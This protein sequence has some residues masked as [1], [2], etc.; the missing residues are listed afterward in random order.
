MRAWPGTPY[1]VCGLVLLVV[2]VLGVQFVHK[3][4]VVEE[5]S[6]RGETTRTALGRWLPTARAFVQ[7]EDIYRIGH[8]FPNP[9]LVALAIAPLAYLPVWLAAVLWYL[10]K[11][12]ALL[13]SIWFA[14]RIL[15]GDD[16]KVPAA[17]VVMGL[18]FTSRSLVG[19]IQHGNINIF[20]GC[21]VLA[22]LWLLRNRRDAAAGLI[23]GLA[24][25][26][27]VLPGLFLVY[28]V[29]KRLWRAAL[30]MIGGGVVFGFV[31]PGLVVGLEQ[32]LGLLVGWFELMVLPIVQ[33]GAITVVPENQALFA[34]LLRVLAAA[35][36]LQLELADAA[37]GIPEQWALGAGLYVPRA[38]WAPW[39]GRG[40]FVAVVA[41][42]LWFS[43]RPT[44]DRS[45][46]R[47][48]VEYSLVLVAMLL[49]SERTWKHHAVTL[50]LPA[51][52]AWLL[53]A[54]YTPDKRRRAWLVAA[55]FVQLALAVGLTEG[56]VG[57]RVSE[58]ALHAGAFCLGLMVMFVV[59]LV[60]A[61][62]PTPATPEGRRSETPLSG[63][64]G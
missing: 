2:A 24:M 46:P 53:V 59:L 35:G 33:A 23:M 3:A 28:F 37:L 36:V 42:V 64:R 18:L 29:W 58:Y 49:L 60:L 51:M 1:V 30:G 38:A 55:L 62:Q 19:D 15:Q 48:A 39:L 4:T 34:S 41:V 17:V 32:A 6:F 57:E 7:G 8:W 52:T 43:R 31:L 47:L 61:C 44:A 16:W 22:A 40:L 14:V 63:A 11:L 5:P 26:T 9:P 21:E 56:L 12:A 45:D 54:C 10:A 25:A 13:A 27:K 50:L 20:L